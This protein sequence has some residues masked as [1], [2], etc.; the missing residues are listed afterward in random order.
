[1]KIWHN[2]YCSQVSPMSETLKRMIL[3][4]LRELKELLA[5]KDAEIA[6]LK[7]ILEKAKKE[8]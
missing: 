1:M 7:Q 8:D 3:P 6:V 2:G 5:D 4:E